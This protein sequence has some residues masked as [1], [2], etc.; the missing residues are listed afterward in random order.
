M[1]ILIKYKIFIKLIVILFL[2]LVFS[3]VYYFSLTNIINYWTYSEIHINYGLGFVKR[4]LL[5]SIMLYLESIG[6]SKN[7]FFASIFYLITI[8][9]IILFLN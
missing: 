2:F 8:L 5:G 6:L 4:G 1:N 9:N 7:I 3:Y